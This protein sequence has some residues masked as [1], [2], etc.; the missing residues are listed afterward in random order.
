VIAQCVL[1]IRE[2]TPGS[3]RII[4]HCAPANGVV[5]ASVCIAYRAA[6]PSPGHPDVEGHWHPV[7]V[8]SPRCLLSLVVM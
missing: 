5:I 6:T 3:R 8:R 4:Y 2:C 7:L 1:I